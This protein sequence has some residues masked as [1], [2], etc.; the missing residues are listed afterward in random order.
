MNLEWCSE[1]NIPSNQILTASFIH[2][3]SLITYSDP[4]EYNILNKTNI[5]LPRGIPFIWKRKAEKIITT[6]QYMNM[7]YRTS[8]NLQL[9]LLL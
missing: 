6:G 8:S 9:K 1:E 7:N 5:S 4:I 2:I 3:H